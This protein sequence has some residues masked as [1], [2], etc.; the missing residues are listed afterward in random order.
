MGSKAVLY[1]ELNQLTKEI[2][3]FIKLWEMLDFT[4]LLLFELI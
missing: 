3:N 2:L 1:G 4:V